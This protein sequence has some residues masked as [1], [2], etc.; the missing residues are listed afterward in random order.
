M[1]ELSDWLALWRVP[2]IGPATFAS[3]L[4][5]FGSPR[6]VLKAPR[7]TLQSMG[8]SRRCL[9]GISK[10]D[11]AG[12]ER[13][14]H[15]QNHPNHEIITLKNPQ[16]PPLLLEIPDHPPVLYVYGNLEFL[17]DPQLSIVGSRN[18]TPGGLINARAFARHLASCGLTIT[19]GLALGID[20][21]SHEAALDSGGVTIAVAATGLDRVYPAKH[22]QLAQRIVERGAIVS[23]FPTGVL[24]KAEHFPRRNRLISALSL[25]T[26][27]VEATHR[28]GSLITARYALDQGREIFAIPGS[29]HNPM[30]RGCHRLIKQGAKLV[31]SA[32][33]ILEELSP[34]LG[35]IPQQIAAKQTSS[36]PRTSELTPDCLRLLNC[37]GYD[38]TTIDVIIE[39]SGFS[40]DDVSSMLLMLELKSYVACSPGGMYTR[41]NSGNN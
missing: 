29:I 31:E 22:R 2:G 27:V 28:S 11:F 5:H 10:P 37:V 32:S 8:I 7:H 16:Y 26:L 33:D 30:A 18:P 34:I 17:T 35:I 40:A 25:G 21:A 38:P 24:P 4:H 19:S 12:V 15:W 20:A 41:L 14:M 39:R 3:L 13:D 23:E 36:P 1:D 9:N 6:E